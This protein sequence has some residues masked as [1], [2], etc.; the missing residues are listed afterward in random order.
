MLLNISGQIRHLLSLLV[1]LE[2]Q[3]KF[4]PTSASY[5]GM[6]IAFVMAEREVI[7]KDIAVA[8]FDFLYQAA[9]GIS[10]SSDY[11]CRPTVVA[12]TGKQQTVSTER[13]VHCTELP[14]I[15]P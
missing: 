13:T 11:L 5:T 12:D 2:Q 15:L 6:L 9:L 10:L 7:G 3:L 4:H 14:Q 8:G 1:S